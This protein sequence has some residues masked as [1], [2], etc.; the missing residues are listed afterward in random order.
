MESPELEKF[1]ERKEYLHVKIAGIGD[2]WQDFSAGDP[3]VGPQGGT[4]HEQKAWWKGYAKGKK[5]P[6]NLKRLFGQGLVGGLSAGVALAGLSGVGAIASKA[7]KGIKER[8]VL[9]RKRERIVDD[10]SINDPIV[11]VFEAEDPGSS[12]RAYNT[13][14]RAAPSLSMDP[15]IATAYLRNAAQTGGAV[16]FQTIKLLADAE[17]AMQKARNPGG[18]S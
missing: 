17:T 13:L 18:K 8:L 10:I 11:S 6:L 16:D 1:A 2:W 5:A 9:D 3:D 4:S 12:L 14:V 15:N 7:A